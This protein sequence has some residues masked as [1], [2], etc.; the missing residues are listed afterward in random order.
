MT[1]PAQ[2]LQSQPDPML[3]AV[4][5]RMKQTTIPAPT[6]PAQSSDDPML[7]AV[8]ARLANRSAQQGTKTIG[9]QSVTWPENEANPPLGGLAVGAAPIG[10]IADIQKES[11]NV[12]GGLK[13]GGQ[14]VWDVAKGMATHPVNA[15]EGMA[16]PTGTPVDAI[17]KILPVI[18][19]Y[20]Q[21][22]SSG[23][24]ISGGLKAASKAAMNQSAVINSLKQRTEEFNKNP[25][26]AT[27]R[28]VVDVA[29]TLAAM[30]GLHKLGGLIPGEGGAAPPPMP[31]A[32]AEAPITE[33][34]KAT[35]ETGR[36]ENPIT[37]TVTQ[38]VAKA[39]LPAGEN[40]AETA[41]THLEESTAEEINRVADNN[42]VPRPKPGPAHQMQRDVADA[43]YK[44]SK[45]EYAEV[46]SKTGGRFQPNADKLANVN[47]KLRDIAGTDEEKESEL[48]A[49]KA[50]L[51]WQQDRLFDEAEKNGLSKETV[52]KARND[53]HTA[54]AQ[55][56]LANNLRASAPGDNPNMLD[57][58]KMRNRMNKMNLTE[59]G[60]KPGRLTQAVGKDAAANLEENAH[61]AQFMSQLPPTGARALTELVTGN[62]KT[63]LLRGATTDW[64]GVLNDFDEMGEAEQRARFS[65]P[66]AVRNFLKLQ[67]RRQVVKTWAKRGALGIA[68]AAATGAAWHEGAQIVE[69]R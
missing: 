28:S 30:Y 42:G 66:E 33:A 67:A 15:L 69:G 8:Q 23:A 31:G 4:Q 32:E 52:T 47:R 18:H 43:I 45:A 40:L 29:A 12:R 41:Q 16:N 27:V 44:R 59:E 19:A 24:D 13:E 61:A 14:D 49:T 53:F 63:S 48:E 46:D 7:A 37:R 9:G 5:A 26:Q 6:V 34:A 64:K 3:A 21:A 38:N 10:S 22:R 54:Q 20:E 56:D 11:P 57:A 55:Y 65:N 58:T 17:Q 60:G 39:K 36:A 1:T 62:T 35:A 2:P 68:G 25:T 50:R 51:L